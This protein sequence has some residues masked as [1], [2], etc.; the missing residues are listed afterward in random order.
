MFNPNG[1]SNSQVVIDTNDFQANRM[2]PLTLQP[3]LA[4]QPLQRFI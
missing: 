3:L 4:C 2:I 1:E